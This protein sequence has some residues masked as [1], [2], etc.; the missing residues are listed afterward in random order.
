MIKQK[1][2]NRLAFYQIMETLSDS[3][4]HLLSTHG[5]FEHLFIRRI[6]GGVAH[7][8]GAKHFGKIAVIHQRLW[9]L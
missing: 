2:V 7:Q 3:F 4:T 8:G 1:I 5:F 6:W 9:T